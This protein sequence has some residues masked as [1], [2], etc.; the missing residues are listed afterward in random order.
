VDLPLS[1]D[2]LRSKTVKSDLGRIRRNQLCFEVTQSVERFED[3]YRYMYLPYITRVHGG[4]AVIYPRHIVKQSFDNG[5]LLLVSKAE[6]CIAG[7]VL[8]YAEPIPEMMVLGVRDGDRQLVCDGA[9]SALYH[10]SFRYLGEK[11]FAKVNVGAS[12]AFLRNGILRYKKKLGMRITRT[13][14][15]YYYLRI[16][17]DSQAARAFWGDNPLIFER[18]GRTCGMVFVEPNGQPISEQDLQRLDR[19]FFMEGLSQILVVRP[20]SSGQVASVPPE[21]ADRMTVVSMSEIR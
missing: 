11:G 12:R 7:I 19:E 10:F 4:A 18:E 1:P 8:C 21:L 15:G 2:V 13:V 16:L 20:D 6:R 5:E 9:I 14:R 17:G 3:F